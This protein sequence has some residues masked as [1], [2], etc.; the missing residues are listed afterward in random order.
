MLIDVASSGLNLVINQAP[1][2]KV[3]MNPS[4]PSPGTREAL[5]G[6]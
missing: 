2:N 1:V 5:A 3:N 4:S 6:D